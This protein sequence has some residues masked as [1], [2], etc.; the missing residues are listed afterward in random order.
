MKDLF[1]RFPY[2]EALKKILLIIVIVVLGAVAILL[3][4]VAV[5]NE[6]I[7]LVIVIIILGAFVEHS[8]KQKRK[9]DMAQQAQWNEAYSTCEEILVIL[10]MLLNEFAYLGLHLPTEDSLRCTKNPI[11][12]INGIPVF[13]YQVTVKESFQT[14][15]QILKQLLNQRIAQTLD[16]QPIYILDIKRLG[17]TL[18]IVVVF[19]NSPAT[20]ALIAEY[21]RRKQS[22][23]N[24]SANMHDEDF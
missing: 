4:V 5:V 10:Y 18:I 22:T 19:N 7:I 24:V 13:R 20:N 15:L 1:N 11:K 21:E 23:A 2:L 14:D 12:W 6:P 16:Y 8:T 9:A 17:N 3:P